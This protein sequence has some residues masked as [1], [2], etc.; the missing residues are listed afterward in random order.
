MPNIPPYAMFLN[1]LS[2][3]SKDSSATSFEG[4][5]S[6]LAFLLLQEANGTPAKITNLVQSMRFGTGPTL[7]RKVGMLEERGYIKLTPSKTDGRAKSIKVTSAGIALLK[8]KSK[9][10]KK[11][12]DS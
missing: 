7:Q 2:N 5:E 12:L 4:C 10:M 11:C 9:L 6:I 3:Q 1:I 8:E